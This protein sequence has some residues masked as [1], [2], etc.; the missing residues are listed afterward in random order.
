MYDGLSINGDSESNLILQIAEQIT[1][2]N[3]V[4]FLYDGKGEHIAVYYISDG[5]IATNGTGL[6]TTK[7]IQ[8]KVSGTGPNKLGV[9]LTHSPSPR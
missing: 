6:K 2:Y 4:I 3:F 5:V 9:F 8:N 1:I 7:V